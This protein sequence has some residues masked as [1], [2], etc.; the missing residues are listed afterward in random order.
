MIRF[1]RKWA[2]RRKLAKSMHPKPE[3]R[4]R[5]LAQFDEARRERYFENV[6]AVGW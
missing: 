3:Y 1:I 4:E 5:R 6:R 2:V